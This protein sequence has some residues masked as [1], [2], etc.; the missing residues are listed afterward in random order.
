MAMIVGKTLLAILLIAPFAGRPSLTTKLSPRP[1]LTVGDRFDLALVVTCP[2][3]G[4]VTGPLADSM[5]V[6][7][8]ADQRTRTAIR[9]GYDEATYHL[10]LAAFRPGTHRLPVFTFLVQTGQKTDTLRSEPLAVTIASVLPEKMQDI[11]GLK[12]AESFPNYWLWLAPGILL[13]AAA[14]A[15]A[16]HRLYKRLR[17]IQ[18][19]AQAPPPPW[20]EALASLDALPWREW[21]EAGQV[22][23]YYYA[24][25]EV[26]KR[27]V[28][29]RFE[30]QAAE[31]TTTEML[32]SM[33]AY[34]TPMRDDIGR[35]LTRSD[36]VKYAKWFPPAD[37]TESA[38]A[39]VRDFVVKTR[40]QD[41][42]PEPAA[43]G[44]PPAAT[45]AST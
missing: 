41:P 6:F 1:R 24:L 15:Y 2:N 45:R 16:G 28:E 3:R 5:G 32:A 17:R 43:A 36:L 10:S 31:Q 19:L 38:I 18:E 39:Q 30:F 27:Y 4:L 11:H 37:E 22:K 12:P 29:R 20:E 14:L 42:A 8:V 40:P 35:F 21:L 9:P 34:K 26:L 44:Q 23:R 7:A 33:R 13:L 25:S